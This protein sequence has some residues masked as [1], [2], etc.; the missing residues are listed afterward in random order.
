M[1]MFA[2]H[3][4]SIVFYPNK[5]WEILVYVLLAMIVLTC[6]PFLFIGRITILSILF[7]MIGLFINA[8]LLYV[9]SKQIII[10]ATEKKVFSKSIF[11][12]NCIANFSEIEKVVLVEDVSFG[13]PNGACYKLA[14]KTDIYGK[15]IK[16]N[17]GHRR[18]SK[19]F[20]ELEQIAIPFLQSI[21]K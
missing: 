9:A 4:N 3:T 8:L 1:K 17:M 15:G 13:M 6:G 20:R 14:L 11:N 5:V 10:D 18:N 21:L 16:L 2:K 19:Q 12:K 7:L